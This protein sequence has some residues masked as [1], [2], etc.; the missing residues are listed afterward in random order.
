ME[1]RLQISQAQEEENAIVRATPVVDIVRYNA[2][3]ESL[4]F[5]SAT[6][7]T[8]DIETAEEQSES[9]MQETDPSETKY[10]YSKDPDTVALIKR[11]T[12]KDKDGMFYKLCMSCRSPDPELKVTPFAVILL[13]V[14]FV[15]YILN[16]A[17]RLMLPVAIPS[18]L[19]CKLS[20]KSECR[21]NISEENTS[22][23]SNQTDCI[24]FNDNEQGL[25][26]GK[27]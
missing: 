24:H 5:L 25:L 17:D 27:F 10:G 7:S 9:D 14:L 15:V 2:K 13:G 22:N 3:E 19:R 21:G 11:T 26:T 20:V 4:S 16:Q 6:T 12:R 23:D 1:D 18:G 8:S